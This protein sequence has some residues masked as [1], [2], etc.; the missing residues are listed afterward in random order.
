MIETQTIM[1]YLDMT[2]KELHIIKMGP[3]LSTYIFYRENP[4]EK[5]DAHLLLKIEGVFNSKESDENAQTLLLMLPW[6]NCKLTLSL[7]L[8]LSLSC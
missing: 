6:R 4:A 1:R 5:D 3:I 8:S 7:S 2:V